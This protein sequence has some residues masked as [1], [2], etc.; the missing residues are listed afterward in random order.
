M[1]NIKRN[2]LLI[3]LIIVAII[4]CI[5][6]LTLARYVGNSVR[7]YYLKSKGFYFTSD[8]L[9]SN[10]VKNVNNL[11]TGENV[12]FNIKN[13]LNDVVVTDYDINYT[14]TCTIEG[15]ASNYTECRINGEEINTL[16]GVLSTFETCVNNKG[17]GIDVS[18]FNKTDCELEGY[19]WVNEPS[20]KEFYFNVIL[21]DP[22]Y[23]LKDVTVNVT[24]TSNS[25][26]RKTL[27]GDFIL[28]K[29]SEEEKG[30]TIDYKN[31]ENYDSLIISNS[32]PIEKCVK[33]SWDA[34]KLVID[35]DKSEFSSF[36]VDENGYINEIKLNIGAKKSKNYIFYRRN[37]NIKYDTSEFLLLEDSGC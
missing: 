16:D 31:Y 9:S 30:V 14:V 2:I 6:G 34:S 4:L 20:I 7:D 21:L 22:D 29:I 25:P 18:S 5:Y 10:T 27:S 37:F 15:D 24:A 28:H 32:Y 33:V 13:S 23:E 1:K 19:E 36:E 17:D 8:Y 35:A 12:Y 26:Y 11:W 3:S